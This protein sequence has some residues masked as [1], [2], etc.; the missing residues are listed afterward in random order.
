L[1][2]LDSVGLLPDDALPQATARIASDTP[3]QLVR[4]PIT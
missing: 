2:A 3:V 4:R 1:L